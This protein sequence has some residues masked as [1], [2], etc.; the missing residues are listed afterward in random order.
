M[1]HRFSSF[2]ANESESGPSSQIPVS[3]VVTASLFRGA[4]GAGHLIQDGSVEVV[5]PDMR[6]GRGTITRLSPEDSWFNPVGRFQVPM[7]RP[8]RVE[9]VRNGTSVGRFRAK[10]VP[11]SRRNGPLGL[12]VVEMPI[13]VARRVIAMLTELVRTGVAEPVRESDPIQEEVTDETR[14]RAMMGALATVGNRGV[15]RSTKQRIQ[16]I[17]VDATKSELWW[18]GAGEASFASSTFE[19]DVI[20]YNSVYRLTLPG[21]E[22]RDGALITGMPTCVRRVRHRWFRRGSVESNLTIH[23][24]HPLWDMPPVKREVRD[25][26]FGG[27]CFA[28]SPE[29]DLAFPGL[30]LPELTVTTQEGEIIKLC[31]QVRS[32]APG[33]QEGDKDLSGMTVTPCSPDDEIKWMKLVTS[34]LYPRTRT[35]EEMT[36]PL[37]SLFEAAG[38]MSLAGKTP[39]DF[40]ELKRGFLEVGR[41]AARAPHLICQAVWPSSRGIEASVSFCKP[42]QH[43]WMGHQLAKRPGRLPDDAPEPGQILEDIYL[44][45]FEHPQADPEFRWMVGYIEPSVSWMIRAHLEFAKRYEKLGEALVKPMTMFSVSCDEDSAVTSSDITV[46]R[47]TAADKSLLG[48]AISATQPLA[49]RESHDLVADRLDLDEASW[50]WKTSELQRSRTILIARRRGQPIAAMVAEVGEL[51]T[52]LFCLLDSARVFPLAPGGEAAYP[53]LLQAARA[54]YRDMGRKSFLFLR[55]DDDASYEESGKLHHVSPA[56]LWIISSAILPEFLEH[57]CQLTGRR[58][59]VA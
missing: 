59:L 47:A 14:I 16:L 53:M 8:V 58:R 46:G 52:N 56:A 22:V 24:Q 17:K 40:A 50:A 28:T 11:V 4:G 30:V 37:W 15:V 26:S 55:D 45:A 20:G 43:A 6:F 51:G 31:G 48:V 13:E 1:T 27:L 49:Y 38:Y 36:E 12:R 54:W 21:A 10:V 18:G 33:R 5:F 29:D 57:V 25:I 35:S 44:R 3:G 23:Y 2:P 34:I 32:I 19:I 7:D 39:E 42:Y 41:K 9:L